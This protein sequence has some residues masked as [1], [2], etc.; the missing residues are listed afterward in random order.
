M[1]LLE[2]QSLAS[3]QKINKINVYEKYFPLPF[4][5]YIVFAPWSKN[6]KNYD[7]YADVLSIILPVLERAGIKVVQVGAANEKPFKGVYY[8]AGQ[9]NIGQIA[10]LIRRSLLFFGADSFGQH[11]A[12]SYNIPLVDIISNNYVNCVRPYFGDRNKQIIIESP[13]LN[14]GK[15]NFSFDENPKSINRITPEEIAF[16]VLKLL[17][18]PTDYSYSQIYLGSIYLEPMI[19]SSCD[20][21][22]NP[23]QIGVANLIMDMSLVF[24]ENNLIQ[25][26]QICPCSVITDKP[27]SD[28]V[29]AVNKQI[30]RIKEIMYIITPEHSIEFVKKTIR[31]GVPIRLASYMPQEEIDKLKLMYM[32]IGII[33]PIQNVNPTELTELK[34]KKLDE[35]FFKSAKFYIGRNKVYPSKAH[36][37]EDK[38]TG[39]FEEIHKVINNEVFW[40]DISSM[41]ILIKT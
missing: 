22:I 36:Y 39:S 15:P 20:A 8:I 7:I 1:N 3:G 27:L 16:A 13:K 41:R 34:D 37:L 38:M 40:R 26:L 14:G 2:S 30:N 12:G 25:Q 21:V 35:L 4:D 17:E 24:N 19:I 9:T 32:E 31:N 29:F 5:R 28:T 6:S 11:L 23:A 33:M 18:L 10:Y